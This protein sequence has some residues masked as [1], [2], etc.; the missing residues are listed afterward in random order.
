MWGKE[1][2]IP[3]AGELSLILGKKNPFQWKVKQR[4]FSLENSQLTLTLTDCD[5]WEKAKN[6]HK[7]IEPGKLALQGKN[8]K[9]WGQTFDKDGKTNRCLNIFELHKHQACRKFL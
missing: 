9:I 5:F 1:K 4:T 3:S 7:V 2:Q 8:W 6:K